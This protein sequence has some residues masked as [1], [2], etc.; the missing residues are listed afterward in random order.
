[1]IWERIMGWLD[2]IYLRK[3]REGKGRKDLKD[4]YT[5]FNR[6]GGKGRKYLKRGNIFCK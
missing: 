3:E 4:E 6:T 5:F 2:F 1:M